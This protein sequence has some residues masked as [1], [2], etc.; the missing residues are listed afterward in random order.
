MQP[1]AKARAGPLD[2]KSPPRGE[3]E[4]EKT[5]KQKKGDDAE[6]EEAT[7]EHQSSGAAAASNL[8]QA[9]KAKKRP[10]L[11]NRVTQIERLQL[12]TLRLLEEATEEWTRAQVL[13]VPNQKLP[14]PEWAKDTRQITASLD[15]M[16]ELTN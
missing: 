4:E 15:A 1:K 10:I 7:E 8:G 3:H 16:P 14:F 11:T 2:K 9:D 12:M 6:M 13:L 5:A